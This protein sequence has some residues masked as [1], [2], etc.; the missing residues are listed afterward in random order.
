MS[1]PKLFALSIACGVVLGLCY[2][3]LRAVGKRGGALG[4][5]LSDA[6]FAAVFFAPLALLGALFND[7]IVSAF[8]WGGQSVGFVLAVA[9][10]RL[11][12]GKL[13]LKRRKKS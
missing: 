7:G 8:M 5:V 3:P 10:L 12:A 1:E 11:T 4:V 6:V 9:T 13:K 2:I